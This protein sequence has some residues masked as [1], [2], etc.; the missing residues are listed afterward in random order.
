MGFVGEPTNPGGHAAYGVLIKVGGE[1]VLAAGHYVGNGPGMSN[2]VAE[3]SGMIRILEELPKYPGPAK[4]FGDSKL[5]IMQLNRRWEVHGG[6]YVPYYEKA[7]V[8]YE[9]E[10]ERIVTTWIPR[11]L[12]SECDRLSKQVLLDR[13]VKF[14]IQPEE[15]A[16]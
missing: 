1:V 5:V 15:R 9:K 2:N 4:V 12:N 6:L 13:G 10:R 3:Y 16:S 7:R 11:T 8:L 14:R